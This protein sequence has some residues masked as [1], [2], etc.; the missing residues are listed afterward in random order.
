MSGD[1]AIHEE[2]HLKGPR[3]RSV[4]AIVRVFVTPAGSIEVSLKRREGATWKLV[5][6]S[7]EHRPLD[8]AVSEAAKHAE[9]LIREGFRVVA[10]VGDRLDSSSASDWEFESD[11]RLTGLG[12][13]VGGMSLLAGGVGF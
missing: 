1:F 12:A 9:T 8:S 2:L 7:L 13:A 6:N 3:A 11:R 10:A 4:N 5:E